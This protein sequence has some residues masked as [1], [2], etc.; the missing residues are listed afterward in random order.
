MFVLLTMDYISY[1]RNIKIIVNSC[2]WSNITALDS[3]IWST[4]WTSLLLFCLLSICSVLFISHTFFFFKIGHRIR[5]QIL[6]RLYLL[7]FSIW[8]FFIFYILCCFC[9]M[10]LTL[11]PGSYLF[12]FCTFCTNTCSSFH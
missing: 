7:H 6:V 12:P 9:S 11:G 4:Q 2:C 5:A 8:I 10:F 3:A 1:R